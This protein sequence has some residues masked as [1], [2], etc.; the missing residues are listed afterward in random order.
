MTWTARFLA[1]LDRQSKTNL[2]LVIIISMLGIG[3]IDYLT[4]FELSF[5]V[6]YIFPV[7]LASW[8]LGKAKGLAV[9]AVSAAALQG[10]NF[11]SGEK[12]PSPLI[13]VWNT[14][15]SFGFFLVLSFLITEVHAL[16]QN[17]SY[18]SR[19]DFLTG[20]LNRRAFFE[21]ATLEL[22]KLARTCRPLT[23]VYMDVDNF[24]A[25]NDCSGHETGDSLLVH[26]T[27]VLK[28]QLRATDYIARMGGDEFA[29]LL[30]ET[31]NIGARKAIP[32]LHRVLLEEM[33]QKQWPVTFSMGVLICNT[34]P[35][36]LKEMLHL[37]DHLMY[38]AKKEGKNVIHY[39]V[40]P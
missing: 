22:Q 12:F 26:L 24:K 37:A 17:E 32:R 1:Y 30:P 27:N 33:Q 20:I 18:L 16:L 40:Y 9:G 23:I 6:F 13:P 11:L 25:V 35:P 21:S 4:G 8:T 39:K 31:D 2:W 34:S 10:A 5:T 28:L 19:T 36:G 7:A 38:G 15:T 29:F 14:I 3:I